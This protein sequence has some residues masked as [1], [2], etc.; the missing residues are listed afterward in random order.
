VDF[1]KRKFVAILAAFML[2]L[3]VFTTPSEAASD[4]I[5][6]IQLEAEMRAVI[7]M[8]IMQGFGDGIYKPHILVTRGQFATFIARAL[9]LPNAEHRFPDV[10]EDSPLAYGINSASAAGIVTG[11][12]NGKFGPDDP[13]TREQMA[14]MIKKS[15]DF[16][17][18]QGQQAELNFTDKS[19]ITSSI[20]KQAIAVNVYF[21]IIRGIPNGDGTFRF[22]PKKYATRDQSAAV[23]YRLVQVIEKEEEEGPTPPSEGTEFKVA[24][25]ENG[26]LVPLNKTYS[27]YEQAVA[28]ITNPSSQVVLQGEE[29]V[30]MK[31]GVAVAKP[32]VNSLLTIVYDETMKKQLTY[33][34]QTTEM[35]YLDADAEKVKV[36]VAST[37][38]YVKHENVKLIPTPLKKG[39]SYYM[40]QNGEL[41]HYVYSELTNSYASYLFGKAPSFMKAGTKYYSWDG[42]IF[43]N[44]N[45]Q[46]VGEGYQYF[47][48]LP[49]RTTTSYTAEQLNSYVASVKPESPLKELGSAFKKAEETYRVNAMFLLAMAIHESNYGLSKIA[50]DKYNL[51]GIKATDGDPYNNAQE[52]NSFEECIL[53]QAERLSKQYIEPSGAYA[54]GAVPGNKSRGFNVSYASDPYWGQ[55]I[56]GHMYRIDKHLGS[57]ERGLY[58]IGETTVS[59][60]NVR[61]QPDTLLSAQFTYRISGAPIVIREYVN[62]QMGTWVKTYSDSINYVDAYIFGEYVKELP[63]VK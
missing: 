17:S 49:V 2:A 13:I 11:Y 63:I 55:K 19:L 28:A 30:K 29:I 62:G 16:L 22:D 26:Q 45:G 27:S 15:I 10:A 25:I 14:I 12:S 5:T 60:L 52:F 54:K 59:G 37:I 48:Y 9:K 40:V 53:Y 44:S 50:Q 3:S 56:A 20:V 41:Y 7:E 4:D 57:K 39:Q 31:D 36:Q 46:V 47:N 18:I 6:G 51:F 23:V 8:G 21:D 24:N 34:T 32:S 58:T 61:K 42:G 33:V 1:M 43:E 38:G 35:K